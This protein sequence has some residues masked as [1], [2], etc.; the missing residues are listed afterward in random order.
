VDVFPDGG[1][2]RISFPPAALALIAVLL[3]S[4]SPKPILVVSDPFVDIA[5]GGRWA[6]AGPA[7]AVRAGISGCRIV[8]ETAEDANEA[9]NIINEAGD[10]V[11]MVLVSPLNAAVIGQMPPGET[12]F[13]IAGGAAEA[14]GDGPSRVS[15]VIPDR[16]AA[17]EEAG[18]L[19]GR[20]ASDA[21]KPAVL[22]RAPAGDRASEELDS[23]EE[24]FRSTSDEELLVHSLGG[25]EGE[26]PEEFTADAEKSSV[27]L[28]FAGPANIEAMEK[29]DDAGIPVVTEELRG[30]KAWSD[31][32][33]ASVEDD[34]RAL[35]RALLEMI[36]DENG[37]GVLEYPA[38][39]VKGRVSP[40]R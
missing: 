11:E 2:K 31:R 40:S 26:I 21:G 37:S 19:A 16:T 35:N 13:I 34:P 10:S 9:R 8:V 28:L 14:L 39:I 24:V 32:I 38:R 5:S 7:F 27:L 22:L 15:A 30:S 33:A 6:P 25:R 20:I 18:T 3:S 29:T 1:R 23:L 17:L 4:C 12:R 36:R